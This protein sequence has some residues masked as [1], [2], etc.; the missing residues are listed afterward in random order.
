VQFFGRGHIGG[1]DIKSQKKNARFYQDLIE[2]RRNDAE[3][4]QEES[5]QEK[6]RQKEAKQRF[7]DRHW[8]EKKDPDEMTERDWRIFREDYNIVIKGASFY[9]SQLLSDSH[10]TVSFR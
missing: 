8:S 1:I 6:V 7:D 10:F 5:H 3:V 9:H 2:K 4:E